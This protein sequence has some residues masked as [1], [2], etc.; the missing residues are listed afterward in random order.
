M[1]K[2]ASAH[3]NS[4]NKIK[5]KKTNIKTFQKY[6]NFE[7]DLTGEFCQAEIQRRHEIIDCL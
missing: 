7:F 4:G 6:L 5:K 3:A 1:Y 2:N